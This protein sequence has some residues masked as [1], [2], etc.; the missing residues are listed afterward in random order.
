VR[1]EVQPLPTPTVSG[2]PEDPGPDPLATDAGVLP[3]PDDDT[4]VDPVGPASPGLGLVAC[5]ANGGGCTIINVAVTDDDA[6][7]CIQI[8]LDDCAA[9]VQSGLPVDLPVSWRLGAASVGPLN[10]DC[11]PGAA[12]NPMTSTFIVD[13]S[14]V[15]TWNLTSRQPSEFVFDVTL[16][17]SNTAADQTPIPITSSDLVAPLPECDR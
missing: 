7:S 1:E 8:A 16:V 13:G 4:A 2:D 10:G 6:E 11:L 3:S 14:G 9:S 12:Y 5:T 15:I 17:P